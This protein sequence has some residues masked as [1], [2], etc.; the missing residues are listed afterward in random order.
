MRYQVEH[1]KRNSISTSSHVL[2][3]LLYKHTNDDFF[4]DFPKIFEDSPV[5]VYTNVSEH[6]PRIS[7]D[8]R[9]RIDDVSIILQHIQVLVKG[10]GNHSYGD[11]SPG[12][13]AWYFHV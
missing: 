7:K 2:F 3:C 13:I 10:L 9:A 11:L 12:K 1:E 5:V 8:F 6:F 4:D